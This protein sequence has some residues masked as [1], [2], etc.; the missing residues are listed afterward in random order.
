[1]TKKK[2]NHVS[3]NGKVFLRVSCL[4]RGGSSRVYKVMAENDNFLALKRVQF[5]DADEVTVRGYKGEIDLLNKLKKVSRVVNL[6]D[7]EINEEKHT[8]SMVR[9]PFSPSS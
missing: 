9:S 2:R 3:I 4:G 8:L 1:M 7:W 5:E 6:V